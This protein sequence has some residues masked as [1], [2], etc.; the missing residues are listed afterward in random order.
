M[1][2]L[3][4]LKKVR[5]FIEGKFKFNTSTVMYNYMPVHEKKVSF[6]ATNVNDDGITEHFLITIEKTI[7]PS[8]PEAYDLKSK[9]Y[10]D[11]FKQ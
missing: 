1:D 5:E 7:P 9:L 10:K 8:D 11:F 6:S 3:D 4:L 2:A